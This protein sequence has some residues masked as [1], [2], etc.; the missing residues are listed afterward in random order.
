MRYKGSYMVIQHVCFS[1]ECVFIVE[2]VV[3]RAMSIYLVRIVSITST[4]F[5]MYNIRSVIM[6][7][8]LTNI[9]T[10]VCKL[11]NSEIWLL[12]NHCYLSHLQTQHYEY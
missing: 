9:C 11:I 1:P 5:V 10:R 2:Y 6:V 7:V 4:L 8:I 3:D 12:I